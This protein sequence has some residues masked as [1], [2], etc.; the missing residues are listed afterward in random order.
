MS[1]RKRVLADSVWVLFGRVSGALVG[2]VFYS[3]LTRLLPPEEVG[4]YFLALSIAT[5]F[6]A[7]AGAGLPRTATRLL[8]EA[9]AAVTQ[10]D[11]RRVI[12]RSTGLTVTA[13]VVCSAVYL[14]A[15]GEW[16]AQT[17]FGTPHLAQFSAYIAAWFFLLALRQL[18]AESFRGL[19]DIRF[20]SVFGGLISGAIATLLL[21]GSTLISTETT[22]EQ[23]LAYTLFGLLVST[24][25]AF[26]L[27]WRATSPGT[28]TGVVGTRQIA[29]I[30]APIMLTDVTQAV[31]TQSNTWILGAV[32][33][34][35]DLALYSTVMQIG[36]LI[37]FPFIIV[38]SAIPQLLVKFKVA[39]Q[40]D[41]LE[42]L[43]QSVATATFFPAFLLVVGLVLFGRPLLELV[44]GPSYGAGAT[45]LL[46]LA[47]GQ[48]VNV[49]TGPCGIAL[50][51]TGHQQASLTVAV[52][53]GLIAVPLSIFLSARYGASG[54]AAG[55]AIGMGLQ[56]A[57]LAILAKRKLGVRTHVSFS[58]RIISG[59][60]LG[61][62]A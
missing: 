2:L 28:G 32:S 34:A 15:L 40:H 60:R 9:A 18:F 8:A 1:F 19:G 20:A 51:L 52:V 59:F 30:A 7:L 61:K 16:L 10:Q 54:A 24:V 48:L 13:G 50:V 49:M 42:L 45:A 11:T 36:L 56:N 33:T 46:W 5:A 14:T 55:G 58:R 12:L 57:A 26:A 41:K 38:N 53:T 44:Y 47:A 31:L 37:S 17:L 35:T 6:M 39:G 3:L 23:A 4:M 43:L 22:L 25:L 62:R 21:G 29:A 27:L